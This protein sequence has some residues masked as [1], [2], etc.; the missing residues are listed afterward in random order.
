MLVWWRKQC[1]IK[2]V[3]LGWFRVPERWVFRCRLD[4]AGNGADTGEIE[5]TAVDASIRVLEPTMGDA[6]MGV[7]VSGGQEASETD[8]DGLANVSVWA[9]TEFELWLQSDA[10]M[11]HV[12]VGT[13]GE[14]S[15][16]LITFA[17]SQNITDMVFNMLGISW[18]DQ[19]GILVV[20]VDYPD[21][22]PVAGAEVSVGDSNSEAFVLA[23]GMPSLGNS[24]PSNGM[25][26]V[27]FANVREGTT[28]V[29]VTPPEGV[30]CAPYPGGENYEVVPVYSSVVTV[31]SV[32]CLD[33][34][35]GK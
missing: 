23:G 31:V 34:E 32:R 12:L 5:Q 19:A 11:D 7:A 25:G 14:E 16:E 4:S 18:Q 28:S 20:G 13:T 6:M 8:E 2:R 26:M 3:Y 30:S 15:F 27:S 24:I 22:S 17:G 21:W 29:T 1:S 9:N 35:D 10:I 33:D